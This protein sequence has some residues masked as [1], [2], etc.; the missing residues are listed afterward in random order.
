MAT[1]TLSL[2][3]RSAVTTLAAAQF[4]TE[5]SMARCK[6]MTISR[7]VP[8]SKSGSTVMTMLLLV[9]RLHLPLCQLLAKFIPSFCVSCGS[10]L[11]NRRATTMRS[12]ARRRRLAV[13]LSH[14]V[15][16]ARLAITKTPLVRPSRMLLPHAYTSPCTVQLRRRVVKP[17]SP[18][19][20]MN[21]SCTALHMHRTAH[22]LAPHPLVPLSTWEKVPTTSHHLLMLLVQ[23]P[24][25]TLMWLPGVPTL[26]AAS[27]PLNGLQPLLVIVLSTRLP[28]ATAA[29]AATE[30][31]VLVMIGSLPILACTT[32]Q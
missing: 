8:G 12:S 10:W 28:L 16:L 25:G 2:M 4:R 15:E 7:N 6:P 30:T 23:M 17:V 13:W 26:P 22:P 21:A 1:P 29:T 18:C 20:L 9:R 14:G 32:T 3:F 24:P 31:I 11:T 27:Q 5:T 19:H